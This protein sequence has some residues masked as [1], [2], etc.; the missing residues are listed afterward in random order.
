M[1]GDK[2]EIVVPEV[3][4]EAT[5]DKDYDIVIQEPGNKWILDHT[6]A[7]KMN[8]GQLKSSKFAEGIFDNVV[9]EPKGLD[10]DKDFAKIGDIN[11]VINEIKSFL[12]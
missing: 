9:I 8:N 7:C 3:E 6:D 10:L 12:I 4:F 11:K 1:K 5:K 2:H